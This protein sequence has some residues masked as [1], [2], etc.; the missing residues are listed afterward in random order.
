MVRRA[1]QWRLGVVDKQC[2]CPLRDST[3]QP[4]MPNVEE[5][6]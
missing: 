3:G 1:V 4:V 5:G 2:G 6:R